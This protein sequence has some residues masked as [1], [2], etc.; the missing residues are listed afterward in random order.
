[1][2]HQNDRSWNEISFLR[3]RYNLLS[4]MA[5][6]SLTDISK[7]VRQVVFVFLIDTIFFGCEEFDI[8]KGNV[9]KF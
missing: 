3:S 6:Y 8:L 2:C 4:I 9:N 5:Y 1:V 7:L